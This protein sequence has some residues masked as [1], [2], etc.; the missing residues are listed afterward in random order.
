MLVSQ[1]RRL[2]KFVKGLVH[3]DIVGR[4]LIP[5]PD[6]AA[7]NP[8]AVPYA[9]QMRKRYLGVEALNVGNIVNV[10]G[11]EITLVDCDSFTRYAIT[12][13]YNSTHLASIGPLVLAV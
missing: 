12:S 8:D 10:F 1:P 13:A 7:D 3:G 2:T 9:G 5:V 6:G 4:Q 11:R